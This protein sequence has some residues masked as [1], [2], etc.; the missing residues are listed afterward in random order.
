MIGMDKF[1]AFQLWLD[2]AVLSYGKAS[3][4][5]FGQA[6]PGQFV[7]DSILF[8]NTTPKEDTFEGVLDAQMHL[9]FV[10]DNRETPL[11][12]T[13]EGLSVTGKVLQPK[14]RG[15]KVTQADLMA[16]LID[17]IDRADRPVLLKYPIEA[18]YRLSSGQ[19]DMG[20]LGDHIRSLADL[21]SFNPAFLEAEL[22]RIV[23]DKRFWMRPKLAIIGNLPEGAYL[24]VASQLT[25]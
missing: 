12:F 3:Q 18:R 25:L 1:Y 9:R 6:N 10:F 8:F 21:S 7:A 24:P 19:C 22:R 20:R 17:N 16:D 15:G 11:V 5:T 14:C 23:A 13:Q 2:K 4:L